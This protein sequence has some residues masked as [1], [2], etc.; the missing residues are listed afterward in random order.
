M[1]L[2][3]AVSQ[4]IRTRRNAGEW[5]AIT[6]SDARY[7]LTRFN[8]LYPNRKLAGIRRDD[9]ERWLAGRRDTLSDRALARELSCVRTFFRWSTE[10]GWITRDPTR[11]IKGPRRQ[12]DEPRN[13]SRAEVSATILAAP[14]N[15]A[16]LIISLMIQSGLRR[17]E[18]ASARIENIAWRDQI[19]LV[20]GKGSKERI[21]PL[22]DETMEMLAL[23]LSEHPASHG[24][25]IRSY[26]RPRDA[27]TAN[28]IGSM[29]SRVMY[30][31]GV[32]QRPYDGKSAHAYRHSCADHMLEEGADVREVQELLGH[33][34]IATTNRYTKRRR[35]A[36]TL[37][38]A[39]GGRRYADPPDVVA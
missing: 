10:R 8:N 36:T 19:M 14:D 4:Y 5:S 1:E 22:P 7:T 38:Q 17:G 31:A 9:I 21:V 13:L 16:R 15:R 18:V 20:R 3:R 25:L 33:E 39:A 30:D 26:E 11:G 23:Y 35:A 34:S 12:E 6:A 28:Y 27:L 2:G 37:R 29:V 24:P 32:K